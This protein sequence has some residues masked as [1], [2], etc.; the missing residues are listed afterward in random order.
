MKGVG[1]PPPMR[2]HSVM[3]PPPLTLTT[4]PCRVPHP[5]VSFHP[6][7]ML[8]HPNITSKYFLGIY[9][10]EV[11]HGVV[12]GKSKFLCRTYPVLRTA[13]CV[14]TL[15]FPG[16]PVQSNT[17]STSLGTS[18]Q[19]LQLMCERLLIHMATTVYSQVLIYTAE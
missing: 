5:Q 2:S 18:S 15:Y 7:Y 10:Q 14:F 16:R 6:L 4:T 12:K 1:R 11:D 13:P 17:V 9:R 8:G 3:S 19:M